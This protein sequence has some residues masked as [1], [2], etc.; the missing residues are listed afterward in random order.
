MREREVIE[1]HLVSKRILILSRENSSCSVLHTEVQ[2][3]PGPY[4]AFP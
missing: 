3:G 4:W 1:R 2:S